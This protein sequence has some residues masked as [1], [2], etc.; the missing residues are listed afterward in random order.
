[1]FNAI[2]TKDKVDNVQKK[3]G[4]ADRAVD[5]P[6][7]VTDN[8]A[9]QHGKVQQQEQ[10]NLA[11]IPSIEQAAGAFYLSVMDTSDLE[12]TWKAVMDTLDA[13]PNVDFAQDGNEFCAHAMQYHKDQFMM[14]RARLCQLEQK[15][16]EAY[17]VELRKIQGNGFMFQDLFKVGVE[18]GLESVCQPDKLVEAGQLEE[19]ANPNLAFLDLTDETTAYPMIEKW[20]TSFKP[21]KGVEYD[22]TAV[23]ESL[24]TLGWNLNS[25]E[26][27]DLLSQYA[28]NIVQPVLDIIRVDETTHLPTG[29]F[30]A[31]VL[32]KFFS[33]PEAVP[34]NL[35]TWEAV[36]S[37]T[38]SI[39]KWS[40]PNPKALQK[41]VT[42]SRQTVC[43][44][45]E[46]LE[47][48]GNCIDEAPEQKLAKQL[49][50]LLPTLRK[51]SN[52]LADVAKA[53]K[54]NVVLE[55]EEEVEAQ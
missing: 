41:E 38:D 26:N 23:Y 10:S 31:V 40:K 15:S 39:T 55:D 21:Q 12:T 43:L 6:F 18:S 5:S 1:M 4:D 42:S 24:S 25:Q 9:E 27:F 17:F 16:D 22:Q 14:A 32:N 19:V 53:L 2:A 44:L 13:L 45:L 8:L 49:E 47:N 35:K 46:V 11:D 36:K 34:D 48:L 54:I 28:D 29:Y 33:K 30:A 20:L 52:K 51:H 3:R 50:T 37:I 7:S